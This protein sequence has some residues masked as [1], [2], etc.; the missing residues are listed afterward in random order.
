MQ[1]CVDPSTEDWRMRMCDKQQEARN[2]SCTFGENLFAN[3][4]YPVIIVT[5]DLLFT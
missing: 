4:Q 2:H 1:N 3:V 5:K